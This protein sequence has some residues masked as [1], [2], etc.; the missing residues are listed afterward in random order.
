MK[1]YGFLFV[2]ITFIGAFAQKSNYEQMLVERNILHNQLQQA[3]F[4]DT[5]PP[6]SKIAMADEL[7]KTDNILLDEWI[8]SMLQQ[9]DS[10]KD[11]LITTETNL[12]SEKSKIE[13]KAELYLYGGAV[14]AAIA[15][16]FLILL[17]VR[18]FSRK[19]LKQELKLAK[20]KIVECIALAKQIEDQNQ[21]LSKRD[22]EISQQSSQIQLSEEKMEMLNAEIQQLKAQLIT[23]ERTSEENKRLQQELSVMQEDLNNSLK[24]FSTDKDEMQ[25]R[26]HELENQ[27]SEQK[28]RFE[29]LSAVQVKNE[30]SEHENTIS[31][32]NMLIERERDENLLRLREKE[33]ILKQLRDELNELKALYD[34]KK[35]DESYSR[36]S[37]V[38]DVMEENATLRRM[39]A[40][41]LE[42][43]DEYR[44]TLE[45]ELEIRKEFEAMLKEFFHN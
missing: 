6:E 13:E 43:I 10:L 29:E 45:K 24:K 23:H 37:E 21:M 20:D 25:Q 32:L 34:E 30:C 17:I 2:M 14:A 44:Q 33:E 36:F 16:V 41:Q 31:E 5:I 26:I 7:I 8:P 35:R 39:N 28:S 4:N 40:E 15:L 38:S 12:K 9:N 19:K 18:S 27:L 22:S 1:K 42:I 11:Q 3:I